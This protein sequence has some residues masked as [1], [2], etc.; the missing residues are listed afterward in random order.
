MM[1]RNDQQFQASQINKTTKSVMSR[2]KS[3]SNFTSNYMRP[4]GKA[5]DDYL[6]EDAKRRQDKLNAQR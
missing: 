3:E 5:A 4:E 2:V 6:Y 1:N